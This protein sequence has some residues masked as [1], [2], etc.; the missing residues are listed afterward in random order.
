MKTL[1]VF[2]SYRPIVAACK[3]ED[4]HYQM[5]KRE[6]TRAALEQM[7]KSPCLHEPRQM[8]VRQMRLKMLL[9]EALDVAHAIC[10]REDIHEC[11]QAWEIVDEIDDAATRAGVWYR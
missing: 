9:H 7:Y 10:E 11:S 6:I 2:G 8:T 5:K 4:I 3:G 1:K